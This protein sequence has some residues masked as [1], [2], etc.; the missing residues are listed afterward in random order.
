M[1]LRSKK[2]PSKWN[3]EEIWGVFGVPIR[4]IHNSSTHLK[5]TYEEL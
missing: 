4:V 5:P 2:F 3:Q 1:I